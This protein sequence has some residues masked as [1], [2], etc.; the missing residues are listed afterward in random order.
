[1]RRLAV[2]W[3]RGFSREVSDRVQRSGSDGR[4]WR[5]CSSGLAVVPLVVP[6]APAA[7]GSDRD[8]VAQTAANIE[9]ATIVRNR[10]RRIFQDG[11][12]LIEKTS[13]MEE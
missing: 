7:R 12:Y 8:G 2:A 4:A 13:P 5:R 10:D 3:R 11:I 1:M 9:Q 6:L